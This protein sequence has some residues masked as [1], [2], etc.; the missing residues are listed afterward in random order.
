MTH[1]KIFV[2][3]TGRAVKVKV[4]GV[5]ASDLSKVS[6][7]VDVLIKDPKEEEFR[8]PIGLT[9]PKYWKLKNLEPEK[10]GL[11]QIQYS[12]VHRKQIRKTIREFDK[13]HA[14]EV[15]D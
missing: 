1:E 7:Q 9:H 10:A 12:G 2:L 5:L 3:E 13:L 11:L 8:P 4:E 15:Q 14:L 6:I